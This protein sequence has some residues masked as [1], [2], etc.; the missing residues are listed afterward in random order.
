MIAAKTSV[1]P[2][3]NQSIP[4]LELLGSLILSRLMK[5]VKRALQK[6]TTINLKVYL[7]DSQVVLTWIKTTDKKNKQFVEKR[8]VEIR[9]NSNVKDWEY[10]QGKENIADLASRGC[11]L[12]TLKCTKKWFDGPEWLLYDKEKWPTR[13]LGQNE[14]KDEKEYV[15]DI[16]RSE[17]T[18]QLTS[19]KLNQIRRF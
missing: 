16:Q 18:I 6:L 1:A 3:I 13:D 2:L 14:D 11:Y 19:V 5:T 17:I 9:Q 12:K 4:R 10:I 15:E 7:K 8:V